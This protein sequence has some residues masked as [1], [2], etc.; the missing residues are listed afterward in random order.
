M[1]GARPYFAKPGEKKNAKNPSR[2]KLTPFCARGPREPSLE[3]SLAGF[4]PPPAAEIQC[5]LAESLLVARIGA[6]LSSAASA[7]RIGAHPRSA[8]LEDSQTERGEF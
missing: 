3:A 5:L 7:P 6:R 1:P 8:L 4:K 2:Q